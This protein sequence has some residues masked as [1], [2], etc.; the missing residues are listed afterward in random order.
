MVKPNPSV[1]RI[2]LVGAGYIAEEVHLPVLKSLDGVEVVAICDLDLQKAQL[3]SRKFGVENVY[4]SLREMLESMNV[5]LVDIC[6][7]PKTHAALLIEA[8]QSEKDCLVEK[9]FTTT[10]EE[11]DEVIGLARSKS[12]HIFVLHNYSFLPATR[13]LAMLKKS[14]KLGEIVL[15]ETRYLAPLAKERYYS[16]THWIHRLPAGVLNSEILPHLI[17]LVMDY[18]GFVESVKVASDKVS[19]LDYVSA[20]ELSVILISQSTVAHVGLSFNSTMPL[21]SIDIVGT[22]GVAHADMFTQAVVYHR[23]PQYKGTDKLSYNVL[24]RGV[25]ALTDVLQRITSISSI[26]INVA[27]GRYKPRVEGHR[28]LM[29]QCLSAIRNGTPY[30]ISLEVAREV[31][32]LVEIIGRDVES[33]ATRPC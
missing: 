8:L 3:I 32:R 28:F 5:D 24:T 30:P 22:K 2:G 20:D 7:P 17:M 29:V 26:S 9:P 27:L 10:T 25:W 13:N 18:M 14:G 23:V 16:P 15:V 33:E 11:A 6:T 31:V 4:A 1:V 21:H 12:L 19:R